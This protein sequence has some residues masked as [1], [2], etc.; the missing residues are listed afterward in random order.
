[1]AKPVVIVLNGVGS[2]GKTSTAKALQR[3]AR[4]P[5]LH[6][7][8]DAFLEMLPARMFGHPDGY[9]FETT[10]DADGKP[11]VVI[12]SGPVLARLMNGMRAAIA[13]MAEQGASIVVDDVMFGDG[14]AEQYRRLLGKF[15]F[16]LVGLFAPLDVLEQREQA[17]GDRDLG[18]ARWQFDRVH[19]GIS[20]DLEIDTA[21]LTPPE[22]AETIRQA[23]DLKLAL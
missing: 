11:T 10:T 21:T 23:F 15:D 14:E 3:I 12:H 22:A 18:L 20:Y 17:R 9:I 13:A 19:A 5:L 4:E 8:M 6:V 1:V 2:V 16:H 7:S